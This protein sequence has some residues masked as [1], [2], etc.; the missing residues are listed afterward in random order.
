M[1][2]GHATR[3][4][5]RSSYNTGSSWIAESSLAPPLERPS[6]PITISTNWQARVMPV[7]SSSTSSLPTTSNK[8]STPECECGVSAVRKTVNQGISKGKQ[9]WGC[10]IQDDGCGFF[11]YVAK[12][13][14]LPSDVSNVPS[15]R[16]Y[17][18]V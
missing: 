1:N 7:A 14:L 2:S 17:S 5:T 6:E 12:E 3:G 16:P 8:T 13:Q 18:S 4:T 9:Y 11:E 10:P 15:K